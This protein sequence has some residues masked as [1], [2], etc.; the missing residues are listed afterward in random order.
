[1]MRVTP[2]TT[3]L[4]RNAPDRI[5]PVFIYDSCVSKLLFCAAL[6]LFASTVMAAPETST[7]VRSTNAPAATPAST[8]KDFESFKMIAQHNIFNPN[9]SARGARSTEDGEGGRRVRTESFTL[10]G[11]MLYGDKELA[12]FDSSSSSYKKA[13]K[14]GDS[15]AGYKISNITPAGLKLEKDGKTVQMAVGQQ[16]KRPDQGEWTLSAERTPET[17]SSSATSDTSSSSNDS[18]TSTNSSSDEDEALKR[19]MKRREEELKK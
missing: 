15:V 18:S 19:L 2:G 7:P 3:G 1:M 6:L 16:M 4:G 11:T 13:L 9:R 12:F 14:S 10:V 17:D 8:A 5:L